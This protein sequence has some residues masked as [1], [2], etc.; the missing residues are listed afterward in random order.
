MEEGC[1]VAAFGT[2]KFFR[3][4]GGDELPA[5]CAAFGT[6][7]E[8]P[9]GFGQ[10]V[11]VVFDDD[12]GVTAVDETV[13]EGDEF[14]YVGE[15]EA[16]GGFFQK[17]EIFREVGIGG[18]E[19][20]FLP[21]LFGLGKFGDEFQ[22][23]RFSAAE[24]GAGLTDFEV[25]QAGFLQEIQGYRHF[26]LIFKE[27]EGFI[28]TEFENVKNRILT[29][30]HLQHAPAPTLAP[31]LF[32]GN[33]GWGQEVHFDFNRALTLAGGA[34]SFSGIVGK[35]GFIKSPGLGQG[36]AGE[37]KPEMIHQANV[38]GHGGTG[39]LADG[40]L[41]DFKNAVKGLAMD[42]TPWSVPRPLGDLGGGAFFLHAGVDGGADN[43]VHEGGFSGTGNSR[44]GDESLAGQSDVDV[45]E[46]IGAG[47]LDLNAGMGT[48]NGAPLAAQGVLQGLPKQK[49]GLTS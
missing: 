7:V 13:K 6:D 36:Q 19:K 32:T 11:E 35:I 2:G 38:S 49:C 41:G 5:G 3:G 1:G 43:V 21:D 16:D 44:E 9:V 18:F 42:R 14:F 47:P 27:G 17:V 22:P 39:G 4:A 37:K 8:N 15:V 31:T 30:F 24:G 23:L 45:F 40:G 20:M 46:V 12:D 28:H 25:A 26:R 29:V 34:A 33:V 10:H 48:G